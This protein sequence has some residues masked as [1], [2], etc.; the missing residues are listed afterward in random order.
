M[1]DRAKK[2]GFKSFSKKLLPPGEGVG[3]GSFCL[4][5]QLH[6]TTHLKLDLS[7]T[8]QEHPCLLSNLL[9]VTIKK[10]LSPKYKHKQSMT[11]I[12]RL[13]RG[14]GALDHII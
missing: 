13:E 6:K 7:I 8:L 3:A 5:L 2:K 4:V 1:D 14:H 12:Q 11:P 10:L 9:L